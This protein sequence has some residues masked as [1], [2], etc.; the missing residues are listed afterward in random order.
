MLEANATIKQQI[1][2]VNTMEFK[3]IFCTKNAL[4]RF[5]PRA[6][7]SLN[8]A[9][10][11]ADSVN[12][13]AI[14]FFG[15]MQRF[16][17]Y[18]SKFHQPLLMNVSQISLKSHSKTRWTSK[19]SAIKVMYSQIVEVSKVLNDIVENVSVNPELISTVQSLLHEIDFQFL[20]TLSAWNRI[21]NHIDKINQALQ[22]K[23]VTVMQTSIMSTGR[24]SI[25]IE[26][27]E[28]LTDE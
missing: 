11:H 28:A 1:W 23:N 4:A 5:V 9:G 19:A 18:F 15:T 16:F 2:L 21:L 22:S 6:A 17:N 12:N 27:R 14:A 10:V 8:L 24:K 7:H 20:G 26:L 3:H 25:L 13:A